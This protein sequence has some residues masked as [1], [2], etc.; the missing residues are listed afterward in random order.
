MKKTRDELEPSTSEAH[1][2]VTCIFC[3]EN[4]NSDDY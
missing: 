3:D 1:K 2:N 4:Y